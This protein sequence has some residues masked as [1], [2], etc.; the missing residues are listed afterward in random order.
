MANA[1]ANKYAS[2]DA[3]FADVRLILDNSRQF[4]GYENPYSKLA[5]RLV[6]LVDAELKKIH[7]EL[8]ALQLQIKEEERVGRVREFILSV[9]K[10]LEVT[11]EAEYFKNLPPR[12]N[13]EYFAAIAHPISLACMKDK[14]TGYTH[15]NEFLKDMES[16]RD[17]AVEYN[18]NFGNSLP[19]NA[20]TLLELAKEKC[21]GKE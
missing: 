12:T 3:F 5:E 16:M 4:N 20:N 21:K 2:E 13:T 11:K 8:D 10:E 19:A 15:L 18:K 9:I 7:K 6:R 17:N 1:A 14:M